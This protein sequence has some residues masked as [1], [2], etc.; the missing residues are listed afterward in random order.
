MAQLLSIQHS[1]KP[2]IM[3]MFLIFL[4]QALTI[5]VLCLAYYF[6][7]FFVCER[8]LL[9]VPVRDCLGSEGP[10]SSNIPMTI[11]GGVRINKFRGATVYRGSSIPYEY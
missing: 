6:S 3:K 11:R 8:I 1:D 2:G 9:I 4:L 5:F 10:G 7:L